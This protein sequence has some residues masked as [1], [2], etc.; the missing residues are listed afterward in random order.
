MTSSR[1]AV[2]LVTLM[3]FGAE[4]T[5]NADVY[6]LP[7]RRA[8]VSMTAI[9]TLCRHYGLPELWTTIESNPPEIPFSSDGCSMWPDHWLKGQDLYEACFI[10]DL[11]YWAGLPGDEMGRLQ[12][13]VWLMLW[14]AEKVSI[15]LAEAMFH[16]VRLGG[17]EKLDTPWRWGYG[18]VPSPGRQDN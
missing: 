12:A 1:F 4:H 5:A 2:L 10:H 17:S 11:H 16:G 15:D 13:D 14:V 6:P 18:R 8:L 9:E 3:W 7:V